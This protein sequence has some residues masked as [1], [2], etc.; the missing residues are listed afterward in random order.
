MKLNGEIE[1][2]GLRSGKESRYP[3]QVDFT[4]G[5]ARIPGKLDEVIEVA[6]ETTD[7][8][9][10]PGQAGKRNVSLGKCRTQSS[11][12]G[13][14][15]QQIPELKCAEDQDFSEK[16][17]AEPLAKS[18]REQITRHGGPGLRCRCAAKRHAI[19]KR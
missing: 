8:A 19:M 12:S 5:K 4:L 1:L 13:Y 2:C 17:I 14:R 11:K 6:A 10:C 7:K 18:P 9:T 16:P 15:T 3:S